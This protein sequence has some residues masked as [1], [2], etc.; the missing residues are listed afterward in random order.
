MTTL[1]YVHSGEVRFIGNVPTPWP[2]WSIVA[3]TE[4]IDGGEKEQLLDAFL[5]QL[6]KRI[7]TFIAPDAIA[8][9]KPQK[10]VEER[11]EYKPEDVQTWF[12]N[13]RYVGDSRPKLASAPPTGQNTTTSTVSREMVQNTLGLLGKTGAISQQAATRDP[14]EFVRPKSL[15]A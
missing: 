14:A 8:E 4:W 6:K 12:E 3:S 1:P 9:R 13:V 7:E 2:S 11:F 5:E 15:A 10:F